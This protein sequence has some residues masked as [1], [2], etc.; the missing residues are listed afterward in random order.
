MRERRQQLQYPRR[1]CE[2]PLQRDE[3]QG[4][5]APA[6]ELAARAGTGA[7]AGAPQPQPPARPGA[8]CAAADPRRRRSLLLLLGAAVLA[9]VPLGALSLGLGALG[10]K[11]Q[12]HLGG[13]HSVQLPPPLPLARASPMVGRV[14]A[15]AVGAGEVEGHAGE[16]RREEAGGGGSGSWRRRAGSRQ[17]IENGDMAQ[18]ARWEWSA[19]RAGAGPAVMAANQQN[20]THHCARRMSHVYCYRK[21]TAGVGQGAGPHGQH[22]TCVQ[23][24]SRE[25]PIRLQQPSAFP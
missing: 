9:S 17:L 10:G 15:A 5:V 2:G 12:Q 23:V 11:Q 6:P 22:V 8:L 18:V 19:S 20:M 14:G 24:W 25:R 16:G 1:D 3:P 4:P 13:E 7:G 21:G